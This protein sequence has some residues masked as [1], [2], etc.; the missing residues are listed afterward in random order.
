MNTK[1]AMLTTLAASAT[2]LVG[3]QSASHATRVTVMNETSGE[4]LVD[5]LREGS[6]VAIFESESL[7][8]A[9]VRAFSAPNEG[10]AAVE[11]GIR[12]IGYQ[13]A[14]ARWFA[15]PEGG[16][17]LL[18]VQGS[19]TDLQ[20]VGSVDGVDGLEASDVKPVYTNRKFNEPPVLP[21]R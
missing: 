6:D 10:G 18:R 19:A 15:F 14:A 9:G 11:V 5:V 2:L 21:S 16:P 8:A 4:V 1:L 12:P 13:A 20:L 3:C 7:P 17:Y